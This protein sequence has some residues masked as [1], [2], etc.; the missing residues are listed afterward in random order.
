MKITSQFVHEILPLAINTVIAIA[1]SASV[2]SLY[3]A[4]TFL[5]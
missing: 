5:M 2:Y 3:L 4:Y 1:I